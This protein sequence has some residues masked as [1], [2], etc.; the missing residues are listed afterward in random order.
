[1]E[2]IKIKNIRKIG[3]KKVYDISVKD[4]LNF[5]LGNLI[6]SH[7]S[8]TKGFL[9][10]NQDLSIIGLLPGAEDRQFATEQFKRDGCM[11]SSQI[12]ELA[13]LEPG[14]YFFI[15]GKGKLAEK[16]Y[17]LLPRTM[18][19]RERDGN[20]YDIFATLNGNNAFDDSSNIYKECTKEYEDKLVDIRKSEKERKKEIEQEK[21]EQKNEEERIKEKENLEKYRKELENIV[22]NWKRNRG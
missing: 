4:N 6:L 13:E 19:W 17:L 11:V 5:V 7:N 18:Y 20:F 3:K 22:K 14:E 8:E 1:M 9:D 15:Y 21:L 12:K 10:G 16:R 2:Y